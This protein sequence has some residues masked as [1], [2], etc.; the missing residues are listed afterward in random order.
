[1]N[2]NPF[3]LI[4]I[5]L[6]QKNVALQ[7]ENRRLRR[8]LQMA[9]DNAANEADANVILRRLND[10]LAKLLSLEKESRTYR[11]VFD[12]DERNDVS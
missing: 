10:N 2:I 11:I 8:L 5:A 12:E 9:R 4:I 6:A 1:M 7:E 3:A